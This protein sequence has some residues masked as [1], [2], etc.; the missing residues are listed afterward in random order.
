[1]ALPEPPANNWRSRLGPY[2]A[3]VAIGVVLVIM[4]F[5]TRKM[6][7]PE[8]SAPSPSPAPTNTK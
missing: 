6:M 5:T 4:L 7:K 8:T 1:M 2:F 3:G